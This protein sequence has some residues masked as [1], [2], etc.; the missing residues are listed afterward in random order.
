MNPSLSLIREFDTVVSTQVLN[1]LAN[2]LRKKFRLD[3]HLIEQAVSEIEA[4]CIVTPVLPE[5]IHRALQIAKRYGYS[6]YD[7]LIVATS[8]EANCE[9]LATEDLQNGQLSESRLKISNPFLPG[10]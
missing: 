4:A 1:E 8:I 9:T 5:T 7:S 6:Y 2:T 10:S 3:Y